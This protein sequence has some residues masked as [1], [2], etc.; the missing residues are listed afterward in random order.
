MR[1]EA[2][3]TVLR[4]YMV[5]DTYRDNVAKVELKRSADE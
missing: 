5:S 1:L 2:D 3:A 4:M